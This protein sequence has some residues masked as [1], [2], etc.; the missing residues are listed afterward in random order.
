VAKHQPRKSITELAEAMTATAVADVSAQL[1]SVEVADLPPSQEDWEAAQQEVEAELGPASEWAPPGHVPP[2]YRCE[3]CH[4]A[5]CPS[6]DYPNSDLS[7]REVSPDPWWEVTCPE[8]GLPRR[9]VQAATAEVAAHLYKQ[10]YNVRR[11]K[12]TVKRINDGSGVSSGTSGD[13][14]GS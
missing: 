2:T 7:G 9:M 8:F 6:C 4:D 12:P 1:A 10:A 13:S 11:P 3:R 5:G 14:G